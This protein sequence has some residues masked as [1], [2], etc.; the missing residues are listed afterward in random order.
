MQ[1]EQNLRVVNELYA[2]FSRGDVEGVVAALADDT[3]WEFLGPPEIPFAGR[4]RGR[5]QVATKFFAVLGQT[6][7][8]LEFVCDQMLARDDMVLA[9]GHERFVV[10]ATGREWA[11]HWAHVHTLREGRIRRFREYSDTAAVRFAYG[12]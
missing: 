3:D 6:T 8:A 4:L 7:D 10:K 2:A 1:Q 9:L 5:D 12:T 11:V